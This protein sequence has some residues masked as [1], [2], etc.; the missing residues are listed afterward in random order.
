MKVNKLR[1]G[2]IISKILFLCA[3]FSAIIVFL[4]T[5]FLLQQGAEAINLG[6]LTGMTWMPSRN[7]YGIIPTLLGTLIVSTGAIIIALIIG[8]PTA[9]Y[10]AEFAPFWLR[11]IL[12]STIEVIV[13][14]PSIVIGFFGI[15]VIIP[16]LRTN[17]GGGDGSILAGWIVLAFMTLPIII[18][19]TEDSMRAVPDSLRQ[20]SLALGATKWQT[21]SKV[22]MPN[23]SSGIR[24]S[25][26]LSIGKALG[27]TMALLMVIGNPEVPG[28]P[29]FILDKVRVLTSTIALEFSYVE[30]GSS[31]Q[32][33]LFALGIILFFIVSALNFI[34]T[35]MIGR[36]KFNE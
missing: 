4:I 29:S 6:F 28:I 10:L 12:K 9:I 23:A 1:S 24:T 13:G 3:S 15:M 27:E 35:F 26:I 22:I 8:I 32:H 19:L 36:N 5:F 34:A 17:F 2:D 33:A 14:I 25:I 31:H 20:G 18:T 11:N 7:L 16:F 21:I 30:W